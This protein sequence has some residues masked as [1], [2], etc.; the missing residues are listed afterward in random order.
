MIQ[1]ILDEYVGDVV[2]RDRIADSRT[3]DL[4]SRACDEPRGDHSVM[5]RSMRHNEMCVRLSVCEGS[6]CDLAT[7]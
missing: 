2:L 5:S 4:C 6:L 7:P 1:W 3:G